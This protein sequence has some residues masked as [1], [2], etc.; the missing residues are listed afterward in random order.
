MTEKQSKTRRTWI[1]RKC[2]VGDDRRL[3]EVT[4]PVCGW[5][6]L[7]RED[8]GYPNYCANCGTD[9]RGEINDRESI[10]KTCGTDD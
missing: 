10:S 9:L 3:R 4:C 7:C 2:G 5:G 1:V 6:V 8:I